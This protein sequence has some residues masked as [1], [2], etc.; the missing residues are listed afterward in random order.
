M[1]RPLTRDE[2]AEW[3]RYEPETGLL[4]WVKT[5]GNGIQ[6]GQRA[7]AI[8]K[9]KYITIMIRGRAYKAHRLAFLLHYGRFPIGLT[10]H[11]NGDASD[12]RIANIREAS[13]LQNAQNRRLH[14]RKGIN[15][16]KDRG[17]WRVMITIAG[18]RTHLGT[19]DTAEEAHE[20]YRIAAEKW[21]GPFARAS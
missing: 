2:V 6:A 17:K 11:A 12:N 10:D 13:P 4:Y 15:Y 14:S 19:F 8:S 16:R 20:A 18:K 7:G 5:L 3:L 21:F 9:R 1:S